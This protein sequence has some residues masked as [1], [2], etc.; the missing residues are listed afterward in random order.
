ML[1][2]ITG[3][4]LDVGFARAFLPYE[5]RHFGVSM[6]ESVARFEEGVEQVRLLLENEWHRRTGGFHLFKDVTSLPRPTQKPRPP[7]YL[8]AVGTPESFVRA[9]R[10]GYNLMAI[11]GVGHNPTG[12]IT[13][14]PRLEGGRPSRTRYDPDGGVHVLPRG[15]GS[16]RAHRQGA[17]RAA[18]RLDL[19]CHVGA[20]AHGRIG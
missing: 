13:L 12:L 6:D 17:D 5:F 7:F 18:L 2:A 4:R 3:G 15:P 11:P 10:L 14:S 9:G 8:A 16:G 20:C 19:R 1:D